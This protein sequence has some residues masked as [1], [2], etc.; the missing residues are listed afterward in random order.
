M[1]WYLPL[2]PTV[3]LSFEARISTNLKSIRWKFAAG[4]EWSS[5]SQ[6]HFRKVFMKTLPGGRA[7]TDSRE[8]DVSGAPCQNPDAV[9]PVYYYAQPGKRPEVYRE[10]S[11]N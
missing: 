4:S 7:S 2:A 1:N 6:T 10:G 9:E 3:K 5:K 8:I 11:S